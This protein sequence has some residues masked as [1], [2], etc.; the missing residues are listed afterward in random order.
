MLLGIEKNL[1][2]GYYVHD[3]VHFIIQDLTTLIISFS[4]VYITDGVGLELDG[5]LLLLFCA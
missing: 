1:T 3:Y 5:S 2:T 4:T